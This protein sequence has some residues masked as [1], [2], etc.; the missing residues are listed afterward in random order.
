MDES[1]FA[2]FRTQNPMQEN[3]EATMFMFTNLKT[4]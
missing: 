2:A 3:G 4:A 1:K